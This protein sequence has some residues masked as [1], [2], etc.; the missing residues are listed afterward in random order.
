MIKQAFKRLWNDKRGNVLVIAGAALPM[1]IG[2]AGLATDTIQ[3]ALWKRQL[4]RGADSAAIAGVYDRVYANG[5]TSTVVAAVNTDLGKNSHVG[6]TLLA[7]YPQ[8]EYPADTSVYAGAVK[9]TLQ[10]QKTLAF[11]SV[12]MSSPPIIRVE[13]TAATIPTGV[14]CVVS[15]EDT[16]ATGIKATGSAAVDLGCGMITNSSSLTAA[17]ATG[18]SAV[19]ATP[20]AA[21]GDIQESSNWGSAELLPFTVK[22]DDPFEEVAIPAFAACKGAGSRIFINS[23]G[24][25]DRKATDSNQT[26]CAS[27]IDFQK[28]T[29]TLGD[30]ATYIVDGGNFA[31][32]S[33]AKL[34]CNGCTIVLTNSSTAAAPT[35]GNVDINAGA[36]LTMSAPTSGN[37]A[38]ILIYQDRR[39]AAGVSEKNTI[40]GHAAGLERHL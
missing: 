8:V 15:L 7:G 22:E 25:Y 11:S 16:S 28:G 13:S 30:N 39:A 4:Q 10:I 6:I 36:Q 33:Q 23:A 18:S 19:T 26:I 24:T 40:N 1:I 2:S 27:D 29:I 32:G 5:G 20:I 3:W 35:I 31:V 14:Y 38:N 9:V 21:V 12:F 17:I 34:I 37:F